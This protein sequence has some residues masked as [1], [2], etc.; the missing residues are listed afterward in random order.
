V[1]A[2]PAPAPPPAAPTLPAVQTPGER[3]SVGDTWAFRLF[4]FLFLGT[5]LIGLLNFLF[6][7]FKYRS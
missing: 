1:A 5:L 6:S 2:K 4:V 7:Y 3:A